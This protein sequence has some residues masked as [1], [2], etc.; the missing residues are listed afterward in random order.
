MNNSTKI[1]AL[2][3]IVIFLLITN[4]AMLIFFLVLSKP[5]D[6]RQKSH[7]FNGMYNSLQNDVGFTKTQLDQY[8]VLRVDQREKA[9][10]MFNELRNAK[11][12]F[13]KLMYS[14][15]NSDSLVNADADL[16][17]Q[18]QKVVDMQMFR[19]FKN[20]RNICQPVQLPK[21]D[22]TIAQEIRR[23]VGG[24][25]GSKQTGHTK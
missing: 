17:A 13:Y 6:K 16:I 10:P 8:Q 14:P 19:Y 9:G 12:D 18:K 15:S 21:F 23:M 11:K 2:V 24:R 20:I 1:K 22:S 4:I 7:D 25:P 3:T 5:A